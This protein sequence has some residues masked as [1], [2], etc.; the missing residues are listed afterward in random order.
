MVERET[1]TLPR[2]LEGSFLNSNVEKTP[3][4]IEMG[5]MKA[6]WNNTS[7]RVDHHDQ[8]G[9]NDLRGHPRR[10]SWGRRSG[11]WE[12]PSD[13]ASVAS[14]LG[15]SNRIVGGSSDSLGDHLRGQIRQ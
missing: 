11:S 3:S 12:L 1:E 14:G 10:S 9:H 2:L 4:D 5:D 15:D 13:V 6:A 7:G 8:T